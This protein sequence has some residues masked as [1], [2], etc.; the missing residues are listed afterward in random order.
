MY[1]L[2]TVY[3]AGRNE[4]DAGKIYYKSHW[5]GWDLYIEILRPHPLPP[6]VAAST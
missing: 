5:K 2:F 4:F 1:L 3:D 6:A